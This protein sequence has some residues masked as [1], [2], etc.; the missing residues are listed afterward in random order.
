MAAWSV[1]RLTNIDVVIID[2]VF[3][4]AAL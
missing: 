1:K 4:E 3:A 2:A